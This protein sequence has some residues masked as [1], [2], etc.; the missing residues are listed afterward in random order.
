MLYFT[1]LYYHL[2]FTFSALF[3]DCFISFCFV[4]VDNFHHTNTHINTSLLFNLIKMNAFCMMSEC[5]QFANANVQCERFLL[6]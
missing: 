1:Q 5:D 3:F 2:N 6:L 4:S